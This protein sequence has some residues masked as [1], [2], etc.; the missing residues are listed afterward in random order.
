[1]AVLEAFVYDP[2]LNWRLIETAP[3]AKRSK[4]RTAA[5]AAGESVSNSIIEN[6]GEYLEGGGSLAALP[7]NIAGVIKKPPEEQGGKS[8]FSPPFSLHATTQTTKMKSDPRFLFYLFF[9][10]GRRASAGS[11]EQESSGSR[12]AGQG[13]AYRKR[14]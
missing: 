7:A 13:E 2:L 14:F 12:D 10:S 9:R 3:K 4:S 1:M 8:T 11:V 5:A 6:P